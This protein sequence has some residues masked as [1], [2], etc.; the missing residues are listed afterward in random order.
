M[1]DSKGLPK[2]VAYELQARLQRYASGAGELC[3]TALGNAT[4]K[5]A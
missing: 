2:L 4:C 5:V 3:A 1:F